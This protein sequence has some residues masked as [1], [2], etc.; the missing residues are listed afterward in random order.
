[1]AKL[2]SKLSAHMFGSHRRHFRQQSDYTFCASFDSYSWHFHSHEGVFANRRPE[3]DYL[4]RFD[5][6]ATE[7]IGVLQLLNEYNLNAFSL[8]DSEETLLETMWFREQIV[9]SLRR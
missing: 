6:P 1:L 7:W 5:I 8:F 2:S 4:W 9:K 3:Q